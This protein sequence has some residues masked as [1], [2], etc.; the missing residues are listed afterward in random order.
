MGHLIALNLYKVRQLS[1]EVSWGPSLKWRVQ[2]PF[3]PFGA[4]PVLFKL[5]YMRSDVNFNDRS[6]IFDQLLQLFRTV[7]IIVAL[8][9]TQCAMR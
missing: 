8:E 5:F 9:H 1:A 7:S 6:G 3:T 4:V 2:A